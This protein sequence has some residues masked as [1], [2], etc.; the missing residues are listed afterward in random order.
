MIWYASHKASIYQK[1][2]RWFDISRLSG[3][4]MLPLLL[5]ESIF[6]IVCNLR[7]GL[8]FALCYK[9]HMDEL[10]PIHYTNV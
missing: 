2:V 8:D 1:T 9:H 5:L 7:P 4:H 3:Y 10:L 6:D